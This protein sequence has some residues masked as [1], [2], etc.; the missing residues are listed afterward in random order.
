MIGYRLW[1]EDYRMLFTLKGQM[2]VVYRIRHRKD[3]YH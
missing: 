3:A 2:L 1:L